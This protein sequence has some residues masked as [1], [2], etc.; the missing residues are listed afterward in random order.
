MPLRNYA[1]ADNCEWIT[2]NFCVNEK[3]SGK[4]TQK[5]VIVRKNSIFWDLSVTAAQCPLILLPIL[6][7]L[8]TWPWQYIHFSYFR[9]K[10]F[11][12][13]LARL[14]MNPTALWWTI[15][16][17]FNPSITGWW[18][19]HA[20]RI[21]VEVHGLQIRTHAEYYLQFSIRICAA[22]SETLG[23]ETGRVIKSI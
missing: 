3:T 15:G 22:E 21:S 19:L 11:V 1:S 23:N 14:Q 13:F 16:G 20:S 17:L 7:R 18:G 9:W 4:Q 5:S 8:C 2:S 6:A 10:S 12:A